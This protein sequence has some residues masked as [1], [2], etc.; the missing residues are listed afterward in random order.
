MQECY[1]LDQ[2]PSYSQVEVVENPTMHRESHIDSVLQILRTTLIL[3][4]E[5]IGNKY[6]ALLAALTYSATWEQRGGM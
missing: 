4:L 2:S 6:W 3:E 1:V 5:R